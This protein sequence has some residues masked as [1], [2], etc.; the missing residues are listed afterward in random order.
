MSF[1]PRLLPSVASR[2]PGLS[3]ASHPGMTRS[4]G[5]REAVFPDDRGKPFQVAPSKLSL[6]TRL[7]TPK[8]IPNKGLPGL[9]WINH[10]LPE[11]QSK[12][13]DLPTWKGKVAIVG[14]K[15]VCL[16]VT[17][18]RRPKEMYYKMTHTVNT[19]ESKPLVHFLLWMKIASEV[20]GLSSLINH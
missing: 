17:K 7:G 11:S 16:N 15:C 12:S 9:P 14:N 8:P 1:V 10:N 4:G 13:R 2:W 6:K 5:R 19:P 20:R 3:Q 18:F